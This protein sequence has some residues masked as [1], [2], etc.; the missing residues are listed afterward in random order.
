MRLIVDRA[1]FD[2]WYNMAFDELLARAAGDG[3]AQPVVRFYGWDPPAVSL[4][5]NQDDAEIDRAACAAAGVDVVR[6]PTGGRA[7]YHRDELT[8]CVAA[9]A[10][11]PLLGGAVLETYRTIAAALLAGLRNLG[12][13]ADM[14]RSE[15]GAPGPARAASCFAA[16]GRYEITAGGRKIVGSAQRRIG[17]A[18]LQQGSVL[19]N[20]AQDAAFAGLRD[21]GRS[22]T[23]AALLGRPVGFDEAVAAMAAGFRAAWGVGFDELPATDGERALAGR[24]AAERRGAAQTH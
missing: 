10:D 23:A 5:Y 20:Q 14:V 3:A 12:V 16:A 2:G 15:A 1:H 6:R 19:L 11:D 4:G 17:G 8:Y 21:D 7:V 22:V 18:L 13:G 24:L 9:P